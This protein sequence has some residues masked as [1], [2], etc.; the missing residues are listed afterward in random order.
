MAPAKPCRDCTWW[1]YQHLGFAE[2]HLVLG[3][4]RELQDISPLLGSLLQC[5]N[6]PDHSEAVSESKPFS[7]A[8]AILCTLKIPI[9]ACRTN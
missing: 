9:I 8:G 6:P 2:I 3:Q 4:P 7:Q 1:E 5:Q